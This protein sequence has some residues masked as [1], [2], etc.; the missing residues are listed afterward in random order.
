MPSRSG[1]GFCC[2]LGAFS[3]GPVR[4]F[5]PSEPFFWAVPGLLAVWRGLGCAL[6]L[7]LAC[8]SS[9]SE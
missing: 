9:P 5:F 1:S 4:A 8:S 3:I 7:G 2:L 6:G